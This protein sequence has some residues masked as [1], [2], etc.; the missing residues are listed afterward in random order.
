MGIVSLRRGS[1]DA[2]EDREPTPAEL[3][4]IEAEWPLIEAELAV[5]DAQIARLAAAE[6]VCELDRRRVRRAEHRTLTVR[7][8]VAAGTDAAE[9]A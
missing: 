8:F 4:A 6:Q 2:G 9:V 5:L 7:R 1:G 3:A